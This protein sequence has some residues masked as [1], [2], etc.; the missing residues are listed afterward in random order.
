MFPELDLTNVMHKLVSHLEI[1]EGFVQRSIREVLL[2]I[3]RK[4]KMIMF[5]RAIKLQKSI[6]FEEVQKLP[7]HVP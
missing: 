4:K 7:E 2:P 1:V 3:V 6:Y 5:L